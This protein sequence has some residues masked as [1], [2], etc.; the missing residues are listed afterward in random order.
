MKFLTMCKTSGN[1][2]LISFS[3][4][5][6]LLMKRGRKK[7]EEFNV[8]ASFRYSF[9][10][11]NRYSQILKVAMWHFFSLLFYLESIAKLSEKASFIKTRA[12]SGHPWHTGELYSQLSDL[13]KKMQP[14]QI[15]NESFLPNHALGGALSLRDKVITF[16]YWIQ[17]LYAKCW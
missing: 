3:A 1:L 12:C 7:G 8:R 2:I 10:K 5:S 16:G 9:F 15:Q 17:M 13:S 14:G 4:T 11:W 6:D